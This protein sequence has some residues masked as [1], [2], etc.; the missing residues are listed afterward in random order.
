MCQLILSRVLQVS[1]VPEVSSVGFEALSKLKHLQQFLFG[2]IDADI[3]WQL[4][5][6]FLLLCAQFLPKLRIAGFN[7]ANLYSF[8]IFDLSADDDNTECYHDLIVQQPLKLGIEQ[9]LVSGG[10]KIHEKCQLPHLRALNI[11]RLT[12]SNI[13]GIFLR[14]TTITELAICG[15]MTDTV[16]KVL[17]IVGQRLSKLALGH[18]MEFKLVEALQLCPKLKHLQIIGCK[19]DDSDS[20]WQKEDD[21]SCLEEIIFGDIFID[22]IVPL[23]SGLIVKVIF[24][25]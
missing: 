17:Q 9:L 12:A 3:N 14:F 8:H 21:F 24:Y 4:K 13:S 5:E 23:T 6:K 18:L 20:E 15:T 7:Y 1:L 10:V 11:S 22:H 25:L 16:I 19:F 2:E